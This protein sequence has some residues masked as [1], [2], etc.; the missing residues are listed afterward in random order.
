MKTFGAGL[1]LISEPPIIMTIPPLTSIIERSEKY[2][3]ATC[4][5][6]DVVSQ[7]ETYEEA[8]RNIREAVELLLEFADEQEIARR[9][10]RNVTVKRLTLADA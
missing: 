1:C 6:L 5:E 7:G 3:V 2:F 8:E 10:S 9:L 4:P